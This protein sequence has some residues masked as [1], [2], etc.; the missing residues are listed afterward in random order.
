MVMLLGPLVL[1]LVPLLLPRPMHLL[2]SSQSQLLPVL[3]RCLVTYVG[4]CWPRMPGKPAS[5]RA[6]F[7][8]ANA[9]KSASCLLTAASSAARVLLMLLGALMLLLTPL[10]SAFRPAELYPPY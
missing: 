3:P 1:L 5:A 4:T 2:K 8:P 7:C 6:A 10:S 9:S